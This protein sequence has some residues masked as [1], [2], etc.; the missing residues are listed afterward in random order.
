MPA[1]AHAKWVDR[2]GFRI[3]IKEFPEILSDEPPEF[4]GD[5]RGPSSIEMLLASVAACQGTSFAYS[6]KKY[7]AKVKDIEISVEGKMTHIPEKRGELLRVVHIEID[8]EIEPAENSKEN[9]ENIEIAF[10][11]FKKHCV[12]T[13]SIV[14]GI[15]AEATYKLTNHD[16]TQNVEG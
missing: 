4:H 13:E 8:F 9:L 2:L 10:R 6:M 7:E 3:R 1:R 11:A 15:S 14:R 5:D 12:V 16:E